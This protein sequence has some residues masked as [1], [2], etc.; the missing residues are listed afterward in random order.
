ME[1]VEGQ[2]NGGVLGETSQTHN[3]KKKRLHVASKQMTCL[4]NVNLHL[5]LTMVIQKMVEIGDD[6]GKS[7]EVEDD[8][9]W[10]NECNLDI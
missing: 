9:N 7:L 8:D 6:G 2:A 3:K 1:V 5:E 10:D 4:I